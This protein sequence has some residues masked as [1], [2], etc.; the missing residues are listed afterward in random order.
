MRCIEDYVPAEIFREAKNFVH[1]IDDDIE[2]YKKIRNFDSVKPCPEA[3]KFV[4]YWSLERYE[5]YP[6]A[7]ITLYENK[8]DID[9]S[10][11]DD[12]VV[13]AFDCLQYRLKKYY[14]LLKENKMISE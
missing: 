14:E 3:D 2:I 5:Q 10:F 6:H 12:S 8:P 4:A 13:S 1:A 11:D 7:L 9:L